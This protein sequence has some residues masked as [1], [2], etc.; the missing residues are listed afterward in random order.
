MAEL[1]RVPDLLT[2]EEAARVLR[3]ARTAA[4]A[5]VR[6][7]RDTDGRAGIPTIT[8]GGQYRVPRGALEERI[9]RPITH[10]PSAPPPSAPMAG[11]GGHTEAAGGAVAAVRALRSSR[12]RRRPEPPNGSAQGSLL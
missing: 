3:I 1:D 10:I 6:V 2:V 11:G 9:G 5:Q 8:I 4:Y 7:G 12:P